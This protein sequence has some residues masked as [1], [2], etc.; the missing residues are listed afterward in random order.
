ML[1]KKKRSDILETRKEK[2]MEKIKLK[3]ET[4][5][6]IGIPITRI[7]E[8]TYEDGIEV[9]FITPKSINSNR[10]IDKEIEKLEISKQTYEVRK[11]K[12]NDILIKTT[13]PFDIVLIDEEHEGLM[14]NSFCINITLKSNTFDAKYI[15]AYLNTNYVKNKLESKARS[16]KTT[17]MSKKDIEEIEWKEIGYKSY[18]GY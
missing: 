2:R 12:K 18:L 8:K 3:K 10:I 1:T 15:F 9:G 11:T 13:S 6:S 17:P 5:M 16:Y 14:Y 4:N 7:K